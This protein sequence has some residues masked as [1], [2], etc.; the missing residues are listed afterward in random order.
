MG[1]FLD[2]AEDVAELSKNIFITLYGPPGVGKTIT[3]A[4]TANYTLVLTDEKSHVSLSNFPEIRAKVITIKSF[5]HLNGI[6]KELWEESD[7]IP[8]D[9]LQID[10]MDGIVRSKLA[11]QRRKVKFTRHSETNDINSLEDYN[12]LNNHMFQLIGRLAKLP[13]SVSVTSHDRIPDP[14]QYGKGD[15]LVRP[16]IPFRIYE[17]LN[18][19]TNVLGYMTAKTDRN[20]K[21]V[22]SIS[23]DSTDE[24]TAKSHL[25]VSGRVSAEEFIQAVRNWKG[26]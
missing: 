19:Y 25:L 15:R 9:H 12:L 13:M 3:L 1:K 11:E 2:E 18:G 20:G 10:T 24:F 26:I 17:C 21:T 4:K 14:K 23:L 22:R 5:D 7:S 8:Y 16:S 6:I